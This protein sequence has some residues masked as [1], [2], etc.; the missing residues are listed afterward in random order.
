MESLIGFLAWNDRHVTKFASKIQI[1]DRDLYFWRSFFSIR[2]NSKIQTAH[3]NLDFLSAK[4]T[5]IS[6]ILNFSE[7]WK[8]HFSHGSHHYNHQD[9]KK[10]KTTNKAKHVT[11][12]L[13]FFISFGN[14]Y[15]QNASDEYQGH[16][17]LRYHVCIVQKTD[18]F[19]DLQR[20]KKLTVSL[21]CMDTNRIDLT[22][23]CL[24]EKWT[25]IRKN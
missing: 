25:A 18:Y 4:F 20:I 10:I 14:K 8:I 17:M 24:M 11:I 21:G 2:T 6:I 15:V 7:K 22:A 3:K 5:C 16:H 23:H 9:E 19:D 12:F 13:S 1:V